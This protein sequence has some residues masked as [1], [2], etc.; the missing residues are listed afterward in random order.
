MLDNQIVDAE[1]LIRLE[2]NALKE[3]EIKGKG[4]ADWICWLMKMKAD[5]L[6]FTS[7]NSID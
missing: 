7:E 6:T 2:A 5:H 3:L 4:Q 1:A